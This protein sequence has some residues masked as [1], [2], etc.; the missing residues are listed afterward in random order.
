MLK[1]I[2]VPLI[3][4]LLSCT[5]AMA[6]MCVDATLSDVF[7]I[8]KSRCACKITCHQEGSKLIESCHFTSCI[9][10]TKDYQLKGHVGFC[11]Q[12]DGLTIKMGNQYE[13][14]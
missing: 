8:G 3:F 1:K 6:D 7:T 10:E 4:L 14:K 2:T 11:E 9:E 12:F 5:T 13:K